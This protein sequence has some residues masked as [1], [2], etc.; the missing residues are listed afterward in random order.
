MSLNIDYVAQT[1]RLRDVNSN[2][3]IIISL[4]VML[5]ALIISYIPIEIAVIILAAI[6]IMGI[7]RI[8][9][10]IYLK[11]IAIP[12]AF[13]AITCIYLLFFFGVGNVIWN[14]GIWG[15]V[16]RQDALNLASITFFRVFACFSCLGF[17][18]LTTPINDFLHA[19]AKIH[20]PKIFIEL[21]MLMY[22]IIF[23]FISEVETMKN[24][25]KSRLGFNGYMNS[26]RSLGSVLANLFFKSLEKAESL[27]QTLDARGYNGQIP[28]YEPSKKMKV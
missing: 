8:K 14:S 20:V 15:V 7:A 13:T 10:K 21:S 17:M 23:I 11:F 3:K 6:G 22:N 24:A 9:P 16:I 26:F 12:F 18:A 25:Q 2:L 28:I 27:Q 1:N 4:G 19:L 5:F